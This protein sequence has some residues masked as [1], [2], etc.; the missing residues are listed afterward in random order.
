ML[1]STKGVRKRGSAELAGYLRGKLVHVID[2][3]FN[4]LFE[5][6]RLHTEGHAF[7]DPK[8]L[9]CWDAD[10]LDLGRVGITP[11]RGYP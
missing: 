2:D 3:S 10:R 5:A 6:C 11:D 7:G 1:K 4:L 9:A 8:F